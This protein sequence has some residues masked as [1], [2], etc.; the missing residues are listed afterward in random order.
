MPLPQMSSNEKLLAEVL[1][2]VVVSTEALHARGVDILETMVMTFG[3][4]SFKCLGH[5]DLIT[6]I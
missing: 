4:L 5:L 3:N 2:L 6:P 1:R